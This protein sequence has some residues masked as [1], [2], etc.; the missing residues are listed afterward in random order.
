[1]LLESSIGPYYSALSFAE[2]VFGFS[3]YL[4][5]FEEV[6]IEILSFLY[7]VFNA[8]WNTAVVAEAFFCFFAGQPWAFVVLV[9]VLVPRIPMFDRK[10]AMPLAVGWFVDTM[11][12][13]VTALTDRDHIL[14]AI[15][16]VITVDVMEGEFVLCTI[17]F[18]G[19]ACTDDALFA[20]IV[21]NF[22]FEIF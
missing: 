14:D 11:D 7:K 20:P 1:M 5:R 3:L 9:V 15:V 8:H 18:F 13:D 2:R 21:E 6:R 19:A 22:L 4:D 12:V 16:A 17:P 10:L